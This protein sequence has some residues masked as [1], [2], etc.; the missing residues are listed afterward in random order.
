MRAVLKTICVIAAC[1]IFNT[2]FSQSTK[3]I[4]NSLQKRLLTAKDTAKI[5]LLNNLSWQLYLSGNFEAA[6]DNSTQ[7]IELAEKLPQT[8]Q[9]FRDKYLAD[10]YNNLGSIFSDQSDYEKAV[11]AYL[12]SLALREKIGDKKG[13]SASYN[14]IGGIERFKGNYDKAI[15]FHFKSLKIKEEL[16]D[17]KGMAS[18]FNNIGN[19]YNDKREPI[20]ALEYYFKSLKLKEEIGNKLGMADSYVSIGIIYK[21]KGFLDTALNY[22]EK[23]LKIYETLGNK[24]RTSITYNNIGNIHESKNNIEKALE[25]HF[26]SLKLR[27]EMGDKNGMSASYSNIGNVY[28]KQNKFAEAKKAQLKAFELSASINAKPDLMSACLNL[29]LCDSALGN[30]KSAY[31]FHLLYSKIKD[32]IFNVESSQKT[33]EMQEKYESAKK[34]Q[35]IN[36]L[37]KNKVLLEKDKVLLKKDKAL[38]RSVLIGVIVISLILLLFI[39]SRYAIKRKANI[40][41]GRKNKDI[42]DQKSRI[43][44]QHRELSEKNKEI[45]ESIHYSKRIQQAILPPDSFIKNLIPSS[46]VLF[47]PKDIVSGDFYWMEKFGKEIIVAAVDCTGHGVPGAFMSFVAY[48]LLNEAVNEHGIT[49]PSVILSEMR[50]GLFK[51]LHQTSDDANI[52]DGMDISICSINPTEMNMQFAG[53]YNPVWI[54]RNETCIELKADKIP[55]G[56]FVDN[57]MHPFTNNDFK[58]EAGD[59]VYLFSDGYADQFG[60]PKQKK[61]KRK[62]LKELLLS[63][64]TL[65]PEQQRKK[66]DDTFMDWKGKLEQV[67]DVCIIGLK[68]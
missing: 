60:G 3:T 62:K 5:V 68:L 15:E 2:G 37:E 42:Q 36:L 16:G 21:Q 14:N 40:A 4:V 57:V 32:S 24:Q 17:K 46:F 33:A 53:A 19:I 45:T 47:K 10:S 59:C 35:Q 50:K 22:Y 54:I 65:P 6:K 12:K 52:K 51:M 20:K 56:A 9:K 27:E 64:H 13:M 63:I 48:N 39:L 44:E 43:E 23:G 28:M 61:F 7:A 66:L 29:S 34:E 38:D 8:F 67:D 41:L 1:F 49:K 58:L 30:F 11:E 25:F 55:I 26:K 31:R 18:S